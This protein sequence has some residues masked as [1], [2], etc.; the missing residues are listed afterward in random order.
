MFTARINYLYIII[1]GLFLFSNCFADSNDL[2]YKE[3]ELL[4]RFAPKMHG[5]QR[6]KQEK[7]QFLSSLNAGEVKQSFKRVSG[8][9]LVK[10]PENLKVKDAL[11]KFKGKSEILYV[12]PNYKYKL[13]ST[14]PNDPC[15]PNIVDGGLQWGLHNIGQTGGTFNA[16]VNAP[17]AWD[18]IHDAYD[19]IVAIIDSGI[20]RMHPDL[21]ANM[22][23]NEA[24]LN[25]IPDFDDDGNG[26]NDDI[27]GWDFYYNDSNPMDY[28]GHGTHVAGIIAADG[29]NGIGVTGVCWNVKLMNLKIGMDD[30][31][32]VSI[33]AAIDAID[34]AIDKGAKVLN[35]SWGGGDYSQALYEEIEAADANGVLFIAGAGN[36]GQDNDG[37]HPF[38]PASYNCNNIISVMA[39]DHNDNRSIWGMYELSNYGATT[40][41][42]AA[43]GSDILS[44]ARGG[45]YETH[46]GTSAAAPYVSGACALVWARNQ[47]LTH[48]Q[49][50]EAILGSNDRLDSLSGLCVTGGRL[51]LF[52]AV[53]YWPGCEVGL[54]ISDD[55]GDGDCIVPS[56]DDPLITIDSFINYTICYSTTCDI[57][58][59]NIV[60][61]L[62]EY[63]DFNSCSEPGNY[64]A[65]THSVV[66]PLSNLYA[67]DSDCFTL[68][69][70]VSSDA[71]QGTYLT[72]TVK[73]Y[74]GNIPIKTAFEST[75]ICAVNTI[76]F[77][78]KDAIGDVHHGRNWTTAYT[79]L[80]DALANPTL[81]TEQIW[82]AAG[83]YYPTYANDPSPAN[84]TFQ[85][86]DGIDI[87]GHFEGW[88][89]SLCQRNL[90]DANNET[91]LSGDVDDNNNGDVIHVVTAANLR[92]DGVT[93]RKSRYSDAAGI[94]YG[95]EA[96]VNTTIANCVIKDNCYGI[97]YFTSYLN[98]CVS[99]VNC[100]IENNG[101]GI[102]CHRDTYHNGEIYLDVDR[103]TI[104]SNTGNGLTVSGTQVA[105]RNSVISNN[106]YYGIN[107]TPEESLTVENCT[108]SGN[109]YAGISY[110][111]IHPS[112]QL[113]VKDCN[114]NNNWKYLSGGSSGGISSNALQSNI[115]GNLIFRNRSAGVSIA[116]G[117]ADINNNMI[118]R[119]TYSGISLGSSSLPQLRNNTMAFNKYGISNDSTSVDLNNSIIWGNT[120][121]GLI[122]TPITA[123][124]CC[125]QTGYT[126][127]GTDNIIDQDPWFRDSTNDDYHLTD[128]SPCI[129][130]GNP[131]FTPDANETDIDGE[132]RKMDGDKNGSIIVDMGADEFYRSP[133]DLFP[134]PNPDGVVNFLDYAVF[135]DI[136]VISFEDLAVFCEDWLWTAGWLLDDFD[137]GIGGEGASFAEVSCPDGGEGMMMSMPMQ[138][139]SFSAEQLDM[140]LLSVPTVE[141]VF[142]I[143]EI[144]DW[145]D[146]LWFGGDLAGSMTEKEYQEF[147]ETIENSEK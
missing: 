96:D 75:P 11:P 27:Y 66:W 102:Y 89:S 36:N 6:T 106:S 105:V 79:D 45:I 73:M 10:L 128:S 28:Y 84:K 63:V 107:H 143:N 132:T 60:A 1:M 103:C 145:L 12:E 123:N 125:I 97:E 30:D 15:G 47:S 94:Y 58:D 24:E 50:K 77:V 53:N 101:T 80:Q 9:T 135:A 131:S 146:D 31:I 41:D 136:D 90:A 134:N 25:G 62:P 38:Y 71:P 59:V 124:Y 42:L 35:N 39:T 2:P 64:D 82:V 26:K 142:D 110:L 16:D 21:A 52:K 33:D 115:A 91:I 119:N 144:L 20:D 65:I 46:G 141:T 129:D 54:S 51:N 117:S 116:S 23:V 49:V 78:D 76:I 14:F 3:G 68:N 72:N 93:V 37:L 40:V 55:V 88:E 139:E 98:F 57:E 99:L 92:I 70:R 43:P 61:V 19:I 114:I 18:I 111:D 81:I 127:G 56:I 69:V 140:S 32:Y 104:S 4:I 29:N 48:L 118:Y 13:L 133:V 147:R 85:M 22:W 121:G 137:R 17:E 67:N 7:N 108:V 86:L 83:T 44:C 74:R 126:G 34:Y 130:K 112:G 95:S 120:N 87:Y 5:L 138:Q 100:K 8:L 113:T 122:N 109:G